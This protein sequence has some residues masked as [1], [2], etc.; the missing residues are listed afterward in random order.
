MA[1]FWLLKE[2]CLFLHRYE[3][4]TMKWQKFLSY[5]FKPI[6][7]N[8]RFFILM[9]LL[10]AFCIF[11]INGFGKHSAVFELFLDLYLL[12]TLLCLAPLR[13]RKVVHAVLYVVFYTLAMIDIF[14]FWRIGT[15]ICPALLQ[16][17]LHTTGR[18]ASEAINSYLD[19]RVLVS[20]VM[21]VV[22]L[23]LAHIAVKPLKMRFPKPKAEWMGLA[24]LLLLVYSSVTCAVNKKFL[25]YNL[26]KA[27][28]TLDLQYYR[29]MPYGAEFYLPVYRVLE[30]VKVVQVS[31]R[32][33]ESLIAN[34][35]KAKV[36]KA[37]F[38][39]PNIVLII[40]EAYNKHH[41]QLY[42][43]WLPTTPWQ[44]KS[45]NDSS[46]IAFTD[47]VSPFHQTSEVFKMMFS[48]YSYGDKGRWDEYP[49]FTELFVKAGYQVNFITNQFVQSP[50]LSVW[51]FAGSTFLNRPELSEAQFT[52][53]NQT[54]HEYDEGLIAEY[55]SLKQFRGKNNL[56][57][58]HLLGQHIGYGSRYP[59]TDTVFR[60]S[61][62]HRPDL[63]S[64]DLRELADYDNA[65]RYNDRVVSR[66]VQLFANENAIIIYVPDHG[67]LVFD[68]ST[69]FGRTL[70]VNTRNEVYQQFEIPF[71]IWMSK[72]YRQTHPDIFQQA[73]EAR[74]KPYM[75]DRLPHLLLYLAGI[76]TP[77]YREKD[78]LLSPQY[79][80]KRMRLIMGNKN[81]DKI[82]GRR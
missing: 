64:D 17:V 39:S 82:V 12:C 44:L 43:Y 70:A 81:Y 69:T 74:N 79:N 46:L 11:I 62:Y 9:Y 48:M 2:L 10:G 25:Y 22:L 53:R 38:R 47:V 18:E 27:D 13:A 16:N 57:I 49:F 59:K 54:M 24:C 32:E 45:V 14:F 20:P 67:E 4:T 72:S 26:V 28:N 8:H 33:I 36:G 78:N 76:S 3:R 35:G 31:N 41:S 68:G 5:F 66:I 23:L 63:T 15:P 1:L 61:D 51:D 60:R 30:S 65:T 56:F 19:W 7:K 75:T 58:F 73:V 37:S 80:W 50:T 42:G 29:E 40:G 77:Y 6:E 34:I 71:W 55:D 52:H 21:V